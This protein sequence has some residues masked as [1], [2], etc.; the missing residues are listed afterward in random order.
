ME[1]AQLRL[2]PILMTSFA[3]ILGSVPLAI[4]TGAGAGARQALGTAVVFGMLGRDADRGVLHPGVLRA[5]AAC[6]R[7]Q[8]AFQALRRGACAGSRSAIKRCS[9]PAVPPARAKGTA[10]MTELSSERSSTLPTAGRLPRDPLPARS[11]RTTGR[12]TSRSR[13]AGAWKPATPMTSPPSW[14]QFQDPVFSD[15]V[16]TSLLNNKDLENATATW[17]R[18]SRN[19]RMAPRAAQF[20]QSRGG[21][22]C[23][24][25]ATSATAELPAVSRNALRGPLSSSSMRGVACAAVH[26]S[27]RAPT[28]SRPRK[29]AVR[30]C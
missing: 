30:W 21:A 3:F 14:D 22:R 11:V 27:R 4:A 8:V 15:L 10:D 17:M 28:C 6:Q 24:A 7:A 25:P 1:G 18:P 9:T 20:P 12:R 19:T 16:R 13:P 23:G 2:R 29:A 5:A 26:P